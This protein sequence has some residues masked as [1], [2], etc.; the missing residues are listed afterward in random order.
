M[1]RDA[2]G[3]PTGRAAGRAMISLAS[4]TPVSAVTAMAAGI[5]RH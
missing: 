2:S 1:P 5:A 3:A 4:T